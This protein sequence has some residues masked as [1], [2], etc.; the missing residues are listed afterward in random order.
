[1]LHAE[2]GDPENDDRLVDN[3]FNLAFPPV[4]RSELNVP[5]SDVSAVTLSDE[6]DPPF[7]DDVQI[8]YLTND[9]LQNQTSPAVTVV[10]K[11]RQCCTAL[12]NLFSFNPMKIY[13]LFLAFCTLTVGLAQTKSAELFKSNYSYVSNLFPRVPWTVIRPFCSLCGLKMS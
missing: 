6:V 11:V 13:V 9:I 5:T 10:S 2:S 12:F 8:G 7:S 4:K 3:V 1:V